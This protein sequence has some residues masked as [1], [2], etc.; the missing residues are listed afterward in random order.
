VVAACAEALDPASF[1][2]LETI[3]RRIEDLRRAREDE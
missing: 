3:A 1:E 2:R